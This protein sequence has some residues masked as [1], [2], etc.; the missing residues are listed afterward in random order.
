MSAYGI[1]AG[2]VISVGLDLPIAGQPTRIV[3]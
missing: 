2:Y 1:E 3:L